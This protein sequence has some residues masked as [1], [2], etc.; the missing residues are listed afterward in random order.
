MCKRPKIY[1]NIV[2]SSTPRELLDPMRD[3][4]SKSRDGETKRDKADRG[5]M[6][7]GDGDVGGEHEREKGRIAR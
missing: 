4:M 2:V 6:K 1:S 5:W 7:D 3:R